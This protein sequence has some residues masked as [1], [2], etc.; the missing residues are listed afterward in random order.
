MVSAD[1]RQWCLDLAAFLVHTSQ[2]AEADRGLRS[3]SGV[4]SLS[5][6]RPVS[7]GRLQVGRED[8]K[9]LGQ[10][11]VAGGSD[12]HGTALRCAPDPV[13]LDQAAE[14]ASPQ[15]SGQVVALFAPVDAVAD[16]R[17]AGWR[18]HAEIVDEPPAAAG[19]RVFDVA[20]VKTRPGNLGGLTA[21]GLPMYQ[22]ISSA[23]PWRISRNL[24]GCR[25]CSELAYLDGLDGDCVIVCLLCH[26]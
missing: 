26:R 10:P 8:T 6:V 14:Q 4:R 25:S 2:C 9:C 3:R 18:V 20:P 7:G 19:E 23:S 11:G 24:G 12:L 13:V 15:A 17:A 5:R 16:D 22:L 21:C 1:Q